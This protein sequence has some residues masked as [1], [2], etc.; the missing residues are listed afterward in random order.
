MGFLIRSREEKKYAG[1]YLRRHSRRNRYFRRMLKRCLMVLAIAYC[2]SLI[3]VYFRQSSI[4]YGTQLNTS[5]S[6]IGNRSVKLDP[7]NVKIDVSDLQ[8]SIHGWW[9]DAPNRQQP[10]LAVKG[11]P[12]NILTTPKTILYFS[13][14][15]GSKTYRNNQARIQAFQQLGFSVLAVD[16]WNS[17]KRKLGL[18]DESRLYKNAEAAWQYLTDTQQ[19]LPQNIIIYG[20]SLGGAVAIDLA[21]EQSNAAGLIVQ[22]SFTSM[23][24]IIKQRHPTL[25]IFPLGL[26]IHQRFDSI[27]KVSSLKIPVL[28]LHG[29]ADRIVDY[30][31][32]RELYYD[33]SEPKT[34]FY[35]PQGKHQR[36]Y[37]PGTD[38]YLLAI[39]EFVSQV[40]SLSTSNNQ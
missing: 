5:I 21:V 39:A 19:I 36:I 32:S 2:L 16:Y 37:Q 33:A 8:T 38:S 17:S 30:K 14:T 25:K 6:N 26:I 11:E 24:E 23:V 1:Y 4:I 7:Q 18:A 20:E 35:I 12:T 40:D 28:F 27:D 34:L 15:G 10:I 31:M 22:S 13:G 9:L 29:T 3:L